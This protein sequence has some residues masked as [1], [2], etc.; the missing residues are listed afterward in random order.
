MFWN[1]ICYK[2]TFKFHNFS[3]L[4]K[5]F[6]SQ[7][8]V[9][10][11]NR[12]C[13]QEITDTIVFKNLVATYTERL[14]GMRCFKLKRTTLSKSSKDDKSFLIASSNYTVCEAKSDD[15]LKFK[16]LHTDQFSGFIDSCL[17]KCELFCSCY[18]MK[19]LF[20]VGNRYFNKRSCL[21]YNF[22]LDKWTYLAEM[23]VKRYG[24]A[25]TVFEGSIVVSGGV[26]KNRASKIVEAYDYYENKW[27]FLPDM[28]QGRSSHSTIGFGNKLFVIGD[29]TCDSWQV[30]CS[31]T[32][33]FSLIKHELKFPRK[34]Y[35]IQGV[36]NVGDK[37][38]LV[39]ADDK[40][41]F[42]VYDTKLNDIRKQLC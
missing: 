42:V 13:Y 6:I 20:L 1:K 4:V 11:Q 8:S 41:E 14:S 17:D 29:R 22:T 18:F 28:L 36:C 25:C 7:N 23:N 31:S 19:E 27:K 32:R 5:M 16:H 37:I 33:Q 38:I 24:A 35:Y 39:F 3:A 30:F 2:I 26:Y 34:T 12:H 21:K 10:Y 9:L 40:Y 15:L